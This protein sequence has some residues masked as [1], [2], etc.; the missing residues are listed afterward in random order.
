[1]FPKSRA[2]MET[3]AHSRALLNISFGVLSKG[4]L[5]PGP[6]PGVPSDRDALFLEPFS[7][8]VV[9]QGVKV[10]VHFNLVSR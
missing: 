2:A 1:M 6:P 10:T 7:P 8:V 3:D 9:S 4:A 5:P